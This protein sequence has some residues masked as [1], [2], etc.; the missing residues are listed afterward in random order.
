MAA[1]LRAVTSRIEDAAAGCARD[2]RTITLVAVT[3]TW[4]ASD[5]RLLSGLG[6]RH[7]GE[8]QDREA[9]AK[10]AALA[11]LPE[12]PH[13]HFVGTLQR[14]KAASV[15]RYADLVH[16]V[17]RAALVTALSRAAVAAERTVSCLIQVSLDADPR[18]GGVPADG[19][20]S[21]AGAVAEAPGLHLGGVMA[22]APLD[23]PAE[24]AFARLAGLSAR[25]R[26]DHPQ[27][28]AMSAGMSGDLEAAVAA[29][30]THLRVGS[31]L[32]AG[33]PLPGHAHVPVPQGRAV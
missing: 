4:P 8:N 11:D 21:L 6:V 26:A 19:L 18:R 31:A 7:I 1:N 16:S 28:T 25:L 30:A 3:K 10:A 17:D 23:L 2:P 14:N 22:V 33:R 5:V 20:L 13:W 15:A 24:R 12:P 29:G 9:S 32:L 27:A